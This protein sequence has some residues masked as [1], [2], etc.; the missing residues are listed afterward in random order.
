MGIV[1]HTTAA[2]GG[3]QAIICINIGASSLA[4]HHATPSKVQCSSKGGGCLNKEGEI[5]G[6]FQGVGVGALLSE[7]GG[8]RN[9]Q[10]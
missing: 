9:N 2:K 1:E 3:K 4:H 10:H 8:G 5:K 6:R 7:E